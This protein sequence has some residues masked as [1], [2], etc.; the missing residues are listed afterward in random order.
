MKTKFKTIAIAALMAL[1]ALLLA[2]CPAETPTTYT[3]TFDSNGGSQVAPITDVEHGSTITAPAAPT[4]TSG[5]NQ[6]F[7]GWFENE[8]LTI[9]WIFS[10]DTVTSDI[11][12][13]AK[14]DP[15][16]IGDTGPGTGKIFYRSEE[17]F[18]VAGYGSAGDTGYFAEYTA[19][20]LEA[21]PSATVSRRWSDPSTDIPNVSKFTVDEATASNT[22]GNG[23]KDTWLIIAN[24]GNTQ[25]DRAA[26][27][28]TLAVYGDKNDWFLPSISELRTLWQNRTAAG[29]SFGT[30]SYYWSSSQAEG[31]TQNALRVDLATGAIQSVLKSLNEMSR[32]IRAF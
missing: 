6:K 11:T 2:G 26:Q 29:L 19:H 12:L 27:I 10:M 25:T 7:A 24:L 18:T 32:A 30:T 3:V 15:Y 17:G 1:A 8:A 20:Y 22:I 21:A 23:R 9:Q 5:Y 31:T 16:A 28:N 13:Y 4:K 14:W